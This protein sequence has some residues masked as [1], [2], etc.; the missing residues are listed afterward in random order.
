MPAVSYVLGL[1]LVVAVTGTPIRNGRVYPKLLG[2][3][4]VARDA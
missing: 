2:G 4:Y 3:S 1:D